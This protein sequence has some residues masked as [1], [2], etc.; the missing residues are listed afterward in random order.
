[1]QIRLP[2]N[3]NPRGYQRPL[4]RYLEKGG[5]RA[6]A[7]WHRR[8]GKDEVCL[9][10]TACAMHQRVASYWH[11]LP[12]YAQGRKAIWTGINP[13]TGVRRIDEAF[14]QPLR[15]TTNEQEMFIRMR[16]GST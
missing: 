5:R 3:W 13:R 11:M 15:Q 10:W 12:A 2:N 14:P 16:N 6:V 7:I 8:A 1:M 9:H 4:W